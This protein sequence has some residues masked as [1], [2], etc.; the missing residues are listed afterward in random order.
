MRPNDEVE[1][2]ELLTDVLA[3]Y[4]QSVSPFTLSVW[5]QACQPFEFSQVKRALTAHA[6]D[7]ERGVFAPKVADLV[8][9]L[10]GTQTDR[11]TLAW[12]KVHEAMSRVGAYTDVVFDD[13]AAHAA[14]DDMGGWPKLCRMPITE[15]GYV[16]HRFCEAHKAYTARGQFEYPRRLM[17]DRSPDSEYAKRGLPPPKPALIG[18]RDRAIAVFHGGSAGGRLAIESMS[19]KELTDRSAAAMVGMS[20][21][22]A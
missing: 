14:I 9:V 4:R 20:R 8:R 11:A 2:V 17:G 21:N 1:F 6:M 18:D 22:A 13:P 5:L 16:Q 12:G 7:P 19:T 15:L 3:Y 10:S